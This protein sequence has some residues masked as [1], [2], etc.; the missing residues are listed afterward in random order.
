MD[1]NLVATLLADNPV[2]QPS[3]QAQQ[4]PGAPPYAQQNVPAANPP[5]PPT[6]TALQPPNQK[7]NALSPPANR[8]NRPN[9]YPNSPNPTNIPSDNG[10]TY[11][12]F[13]MSSG[14][15]G[16]SISLGGGAGG[17]PF[18][19]SESE[20]E[21]ED[22]RGSFVGISISGGNN[23]T[24]F[25]NNFGNVEMPGRIV[26]N[27]RDWGA[28]PRSMWPGDVVNDYQQGMAKGTRAMG[29]AAGLMNNLGMG[30]GMGMGPWGMNLGGRPQPP[31]SKKKRGWM[32]KR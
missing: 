8:S 17:W 24:A 16:Q 18:G 5:Q 22:G 20:S 2:N 13:N 7:P 1:P 31:R 6:T 3:A 4:Q 30:M 25:G 32:R 10:N 27:G 12:A 26:I 19:E 15:A 14:P 29:E 11:N 23:Y 9:N 21:S 28:V